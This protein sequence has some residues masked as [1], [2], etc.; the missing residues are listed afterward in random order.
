HDKIVQILDPRYYDDREAALR[1]L[2]GQAAFLVAPRDE[3]SSADLAALLSRPQNAPY[4]GRVRPLPLD[5]RL[6]R[7]SSTAVR[8]AALRGEGLRELVPPTVERFLDATGAYKAP[9]GE[10][11]YG[12]RVAALD[13]L[14]G[15]SEPALRAG[16]AA[17]PGQRR[18]DS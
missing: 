8:A 17:P 3:H 18:P 1:R 12:H 4:A 5:P 11:A 14:E 7:L 10:G 15:L 9:D 16:A 13:A 6:A 2:F